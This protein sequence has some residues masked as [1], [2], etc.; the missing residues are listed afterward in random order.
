[1]LAILSPAKSLDFETLGRGERAL[2][3]T[4]PAL[5]EQS[6]RLITSTRR[7]SSKK[8]Q[9]L[10]KISPALADLNRQR[11]HDFEVPFTEG[12]A[13]PA[14]LA[15][16]G[17][18][19]VGL[20][21]NGLSDTELTYAQDHLGILS[22]L[23][24]LLRPLDLMQ[25]YRLEMGTRLKT[26]RGATLYTFWGDR[27]TKTLNSRTEGHA[28]RSV[29]NLASNEYFKSVNVKKLTGGVVTCH[30]K[31]VKDGDARVIGLHAKRARG[32]MARWVIQEKPGSRE[33]LKACTFDDYEFQPDVSDPDSFVFARPWRSG[34]LVQQ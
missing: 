17:G 13:K 23:Y 21:A 2:P 30:F 24:G 22:G 28:D 29:I 16:A 15:F 32:R 18:T 12:N 4:I 34:A 8:L 3:L 25:P 33:D 5:L 27:I 31:E 26:R 9:A 14:A 11:Y 6:Q 20:A 19:Y 1:M 10:M 7:L